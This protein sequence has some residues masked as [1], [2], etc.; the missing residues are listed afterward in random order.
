MR[1]AMMMP[2]MARRAFAHASGVRT[3][4]RVAFYA[5][6]ASSRAHVDAVDGELCRDIAEVW[7][8]REPDLFQ[9]WKIITRFRKEMF[10]ARA[11]RDTILAQLG[12]L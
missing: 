2:A 5:G 9:E 1:L 6:V 12:R 7:F 10:S 8:P 3:A 4:R 11:A